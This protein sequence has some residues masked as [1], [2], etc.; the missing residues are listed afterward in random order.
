MP[1]TQDGFSTKTQEQ[2]RADLESLFK[3]TFPEF[4]SDTLSFGGQLIDILAELIT[5]EQQEALFT[6]QSYDR[7]SATGVALDRLGALIDILRGGATQSSSEGTITG[8]GGTPIPDLSRVR[9]DA[10][11]TVWEI[12]GGPYVIPGVGAGQTLTGI[13]LQSQ[14]TGP[15]AATAT[16]DWTIIDVQSGWASWE[17]TEDATPGRNSQSN[18]DYRASQDTGLSARGQGP[19]LALDANIEKVEGVVTSKTAHNPSVS[20][21]DSRGIPWKAMNP[22]VETSPAVPTAALKQAIALAIWNTI[23]GGGQSFGTDVTEIVIDEEGQAQS[24]SYDL[25]S[26]INVWIVID[27]TTSDEDEAITPNIETTIEEYV[28]E[29]ANLQMTGIGQNTRDYEI[30]GLVNDSGVTG[31]TSVSVLL[32]RTSF[33]GPFDSP[34]VPISIR[35]RADFDLTRVQVTVV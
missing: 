7:R 16:T 34:E 15:I 28:A 31:V 35:Q 27:I 12:T 23:G 2:N 19:L 8:T 5:A 1:L 4:E 10:T 9:L 14:D 6:Y 13:P 30:V 22:V 17:T 21:V 26:E 29:Q 20:P 18:K 25:V 33:A 32:S 24:I 3:G 11:N